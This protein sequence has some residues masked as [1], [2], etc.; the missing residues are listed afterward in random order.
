MDVKWTSEHSVNVVEI[1]EQHR[2]FIELINLMREAVEHRDPDPDPVLDKALALLTSYAS[3]HFD[4]EEKL[5]KKCDYSG[6]DKLHSEHTDL[7]KR[8]D[9]L[10]KQKQSAPDVYDFYNSVLDFMADWLNQHLLVEDKQFSACLN[11][12]GIH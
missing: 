8:L 9:D 1:D 4:S 10:V 11:E 7:L 2:F 6:F 12:H 5:V 3:F